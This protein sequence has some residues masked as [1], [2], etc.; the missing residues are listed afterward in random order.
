MD[1]QQADRF[2]PIHRR[3]GGSGDPEPKGYLTRDRGGPDLAWV[4]KGLL[5][6]VVGFI[7]VMAFLGIIMAGIADMGSTAP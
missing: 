7:I 6:V 5:A 3:P 1:D 4:G 2:G